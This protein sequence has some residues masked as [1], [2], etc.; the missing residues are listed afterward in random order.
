MQIRLASDSLIVG[1]LRDQDPLI[2][3]VSFRR[4]WQLKIGVQDHVALGD[5][6]EKNHYD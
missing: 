5:M 4:F 1:W 6:N 3:T 2:E